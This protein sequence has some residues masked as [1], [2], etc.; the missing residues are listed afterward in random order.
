MKAI[1]AYESLFGNTR[2]VAESIAIGMSEFAD[3]TVLNIN[4]LNLDKLAG[5][6]LLVVGAPTHAH[7]ISTSASRKEAER[8]SKQP[9]RRLRLERDATGMGVREWI[10]TLPEST[11]LCAAF[12]TRADVLKLLSGAASTTIDKRLRRKGMRAIIDPESF[13]VSTQGELNPGESTRAQE[14]GATVARASEVP[15]YT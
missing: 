11:G 7:T 15:V 2:R 5:L 1:V 9:A 10:E 13:L 12:D 4:R 14:W 6:D 3:V 8:Q